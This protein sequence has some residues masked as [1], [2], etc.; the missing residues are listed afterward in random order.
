MV[1]SAAVAVPLAVLML[2][3]VF[4]MVVAIGFALL[5]QLTAEQREHLFSDGSR[6]SG[7][8]LDACCP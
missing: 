3:V 8:D 4:V 2:V 6:R 7:I 5:G 1:L